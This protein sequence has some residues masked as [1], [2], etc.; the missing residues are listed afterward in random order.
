MRRV[1][2]AIVVLACW[3]ASSAAFAQTARATGVVR[4][5]DGKPVRGATIRASNPDAYPP[6]MISTTDERGRW[7]MIGLR[8]GTYTFHVEA[9][10]FFPVEAPAT[11]RTA[12]S[13][14][15]VFSLA[16][17]PGPIPGALP[18]NIQAQLA[19]ANMLRDQGRIDQA[20]SA[21]QEIRARNPKLTYVNLVLGNMYRQKARQESDPTARRSQIDRAIEAYTALLETDAGDERAQRELETARAEAAAAVN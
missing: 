18:A 21:Y 8:A 19:A 20:I 4:D 3:C 9:P 17:D 16:R 10:G 13:A 14:P 11:V 2:L 12:A 7:A 15:L 6:Q 5:L 1:P